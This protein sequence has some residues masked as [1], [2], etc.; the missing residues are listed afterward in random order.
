MEGPT[1]P[2][3]EPSE[4]E[5]K[6]QILDSVI[7]MLKSGSPRIVGIN[8]VRDFLR[9]HGLDLDENGFIINFEN[10][11]FVEPYSFSREAFEEV[12][13]PVDDPLSEYSR[14]ETECSW[15]IGAKEKLHVSDLHT[16]YTFD[17]EAHPV[18]DDKINLNRLAE[19]TGMTYSVVCE[20]SDSVDL[21]KDIDSTVIDFSNM[22]GEYDVSLNCFDCGYEGEP[23]SW[24]ED[25][26]CERGVL[27]CPECSCL[28]EVFSIEVCTSCQSSHRWENVTPEREEDEDAES[29]MYWEPSCPEC[30]AGPNFLES[31]DR[32]N[33]EKYES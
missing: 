12:L 10:D 18:K 26:E 27:R 6:Q 21:V 31:Q 32:Y 4:P 14:P 30:D 20:W 5:E 9:S 22:D 1:N 24:N 23:D 2:T 3:I 7:E 16:V 8:Q 11:E 13:S 19:A 25:E 29:A 15:I 28:W 33:I 17:G